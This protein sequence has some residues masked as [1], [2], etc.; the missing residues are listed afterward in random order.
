MGSQE[1]RPE[2]DR[3]SQK[4]DPL[5]FLNGLNG[6]TT[7]N[8]NHITMQFASWLG[9]RSE[10][11]DT[12]AV[13][14]FFPLHLLPAIALLAGL[15]LSRRGYGLWIPSCALC[16]VCFEKR[17]KCEKKNLR[18]LTTKHLVSECACRVPEITNGTVG[19]RLPACNVPNRADRKISDMHRFF[20]TNREKNV[21][22]FSIEKIP[23]GRGSVIQ[24]SRML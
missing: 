18:L 22:I 23:S 7:R 6:R 1:T 14:L 21:F 5:H 4:S 15:S 3:M 24:K 12:A 10:R 19:A 17:R 9:I 8:I 20:V 11:G 16:R 2:S 13:S